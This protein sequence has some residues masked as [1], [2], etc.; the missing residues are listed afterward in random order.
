VRRVLEQNGGNRTTAA[1][2][3]GISRQT[4]QVKLARFGRG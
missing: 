1:R 2:S 3:L 4:L